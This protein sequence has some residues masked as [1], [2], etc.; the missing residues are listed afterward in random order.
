MVI[1]ERPFRGAGVPLEV[2]GGWGVTW[3]GV[4]YSGYGALASR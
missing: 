4:L 2:G 3:A 1:G